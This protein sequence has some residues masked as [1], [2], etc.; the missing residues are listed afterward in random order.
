MSTKKPDVADSW[1]EIDEE[2]LP[3]TISILKN[4]SNN[5]TGTSTKV[6]SRASTSAVRQQDTLSQTLEDEL[7]PK[8]VPRPMQILKRPQSSAGTDG[9]SPVDNKPKTQ[10]KSLDQR[11][12]EYAKARLRILGS[13][14]DEEE[15]ETK[16]A[17]ATTTTSNSTGTNGLRI[18]N[19]NNNNN[20]NNS[21]NN[22]IGGNSGVGVGGVG[23]VGNPANSSAN[24]AYRY[25]P[26]YRQQAPIGTFPPS[27][28]N[29]PPPPPGAGQSAGMYYPHM[30]NQ[31]QH[32]PMHSP[33]HPLHHPPSAFPHVPHHHHHLQHNGHPYQHQQHFG[34]HINSAPGTQHM[35]GGRNGGNV[36]GG[37]G[38]FP[39]GGPSSFAEVNGGAPLL[40]HAPPGVHPNHPYGVGATGGY[41]Q[42]NANLVGHGGANISN[43]QHVLRLPAGPDGSQGFNVRR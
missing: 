21:N 14:H 30:G 4:T 7:R 39:K 13:A 29:G 34:Q 9:K 20:N 26:P 38:F 24:N 40:G 10:I 36:P 25:Y 19:V 12:E 35:Y 37:S 18:G 17:T 6:N 27:M 23:V 31:S 16:K 3:G 42:A 43:N 32:H 11:K 8:M 33:H 28:Q 2:R 41:G 1:E 5:T 22:G 15:T